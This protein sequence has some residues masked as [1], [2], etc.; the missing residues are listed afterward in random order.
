MKTLAIETSGKRGSIALLDAG[1]LVASQS[2][3]T[4]ARSAQTL[5]KSMDETLKRHQWRPTQI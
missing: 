1:N 5:A 4:I 2:L 3:D